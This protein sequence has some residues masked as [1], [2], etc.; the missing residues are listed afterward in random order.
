MDNKY[1]IN[2][3][4][5]LPIDPLVYG[6][7]KKDKLFE[8][9]KAHLILII[10]RKSRVIM[11]DGEKI[12]IKIEAIKASGFKGKI[13]FASTAPVCSKTTKFLQEN[14]TDVLLL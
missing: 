6:L 7:G 5:V 8:V 1:L 11:K 9:S 4:Q 3:K 2:G 10:D 13:S 12:S 14:G